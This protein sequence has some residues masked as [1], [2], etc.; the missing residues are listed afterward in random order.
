MKKTKVKTHLRKTRRKRTR[1]KAH[2]RNY[3]SGPK[4]YFEP[5]RVE[6]M[7]R[8]EIEELKE[9]MFKKPE[10]TRRT[11]LGIPTERQ[12]LT[13]EQE[14]ILDQYQTALWTGDK[15]LQRILKPQVE[16]IR[17]NLGSDWM[18][19]RLKK[20]QMYRWVQTKK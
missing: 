10:P 2:T 5:R 1:V 14:G 13:E 19:S 3:K 8:K 4:L 12:R 16:K 11:G 7:S 18:F 17:M 9:K 15:E 6:E 20:G